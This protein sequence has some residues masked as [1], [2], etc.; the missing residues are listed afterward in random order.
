[1]PEIKVEYPK[2]KRS[3]EMVLVQMLRDK[4]GWLDYM[5]ITQAL[6]NLR[7]HADSMKKE[8]DRICS[9]SSRKEIQEEQ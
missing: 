1:M 9:D 6:W 3:A 4:R 5:D 2:G 7:F 8:R